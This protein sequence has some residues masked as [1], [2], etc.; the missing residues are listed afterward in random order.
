MNE[1]QTQPTQSRV[2]LRADRNERPADSAGPSTS[3]ISFSRMGDRVGADH[4][5]SLGAGFRDQP[6]PCYFAGDT[7]RGC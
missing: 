1:P 7:G 4:N 5:P 2:L 3:H 6:V